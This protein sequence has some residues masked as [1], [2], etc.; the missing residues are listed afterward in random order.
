MSA[1]TY[2][3]KVKCPEGHLF[4]L[5]RRV[6]TAG[7]KVRTYCIF[8]KRAHQIIAGPVPAPKGSK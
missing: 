6:G 3:D 7:K 2:T 5:A 1:K 8:C 4:N